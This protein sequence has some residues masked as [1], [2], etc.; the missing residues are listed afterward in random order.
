MGLERRPARAGA[1]AGRRVL[2]ALV[3]VVGV[4]IV[5]GVW[6]AAR[7]APPGG[8]VRFDA[9]AAV[10]RGPARV[11]GIER[12]IR[13]RGRGRLPQYLAPAR[14]A[15]VDSARIGLLAARLVS[16]A[17]TAQAPVVAL[18]PRDSV[19]GLALV[20]RLVVTPGEPGLLV[21]APRSARP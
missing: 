18:V 17:A 3:L 19:A 10:V 14:G 6:R 21:F 12:L 13:A 4:G 16:G 15:V 5:A 8:D 9:R 20:A 7:R 2:R 11:A 1:P